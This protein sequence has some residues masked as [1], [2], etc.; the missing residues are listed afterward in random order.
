[1]ILL[2]GKSGAGKDTVIELLKQ[3]GFQKIVAYTTRPPR[4][5]EVDGETYHFCKVSEFSDLLKKDYFIVTEIFF[6]NDGIWEYGVARGDVSRD[7][8]KKD[9]RT[10]L[11]LNPKTGKK[12]VTEHPELEIKTIYLHCSTRILEK[13]LLERGDNPTETLRR[14]A[15]D[16]QDFKD[17]GK[18]VD[19][20]IYNGSGNP[21]VAV[22][23]IIRYLENDR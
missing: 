6:T 13:R 21:K 1:M 4:N 9:D 20:E 16:E 2:M 22:D 15:Q 7:V 11:V 5:G 12:L 18:W 23:S 17:I 19:V 3:R 8:L 14:L 10:I